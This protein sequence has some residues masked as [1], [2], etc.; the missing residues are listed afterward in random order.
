MNDAWLSKI[1]YNAR[2]ELNLMNIKTYN[3]KTFPACL[4][5]YEE[6]IHWNRRHDELTSLHIY[7]INSDN[8]YQQRDMLHDINKEDD[9][10]RVLYERTTNHSI[11]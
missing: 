3:M 8:S 2:T 11:C 1:Y 6:N 5:V 10:F 9:S 4:F 7:D